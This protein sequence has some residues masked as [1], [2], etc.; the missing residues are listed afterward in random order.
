[1]N[2][3]VLKLIAMIIMVLDHIPNFYDGMPIY[4]HWIGRLSAPIFVFCL[5]QGFIHTKNRKK[6]FIRL[7]IL[8]VIMA[9]ENYVL[10]L[11]YS[12]ATILVLVFVILFLVDEI[13]LKKEKY[14]LHLVYF[15]SWQLIINIILFSIQDIFEPSYDFML[16]LAHISGSFI[17]I[18]LIVFFVALAIGFYCFKDSKVKTVGCIVVVSLSILAL[19]NHSAI[20]RVSYL[21]GN[22]ASLI[23]NLLD[24]CFGI[25]VMIDRNIWYGF[26][27]WMMIF[28]AIPIFLYNDKKGRGLK[29][30]F[31][32]FY[33]GH[34]IILHFLTI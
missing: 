6:Y 8:N 24:V 11:N 33:P 2:S 31:Y 17:E 18:D 27:Q 15:I 19:I 30:L 21:L 22:K 7:Y 28:S 25:P 20:N 26:P 32:V 29:Y 12:F 9:I 3:T 1:M 34:L 4:F 10:N 5:V 13:K 23:R 16:M 14:K